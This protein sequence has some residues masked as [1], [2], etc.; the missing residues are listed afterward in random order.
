M[1]I[2]GILVLATPI[3]SMEKSAFT[4]LLVQLRTASDSEKID[5]LNALYTKRYTTIQVQKILGTFKYGSHRLDAFE[6]LSTKLEDPQNKDFIL[7]SF[8]YDHPIFQKDAQKIADK[9]S[10][11][12]I[13]S[14]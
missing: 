9:I 8:E 14:R 7:D 10:A 4:K 2:I 3:I 5:K 6:V 12:C 1:F 11:V 13:L